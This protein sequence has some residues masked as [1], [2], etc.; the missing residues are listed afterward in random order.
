MS[1][2]AHNTSWLK[3]QLAYPHSLW[4][5]FSVNPQEISLHNNWVIKVSHECWGCGNAGAFLPDR[6]KCKT[7]RP[8]QKQICCMSK[9]IYLSTNL[10]H[11]HKPKHV[12]SRN[13]HMCVYGSIIQK[14]QMWR[15]SS[16][17][18]ADEQ[19][20]QM[21]QAYLPTTYKDKERGPLSLCPTKLLMRQA[22]QTAHSS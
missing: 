17:P 18:A 13:L 22:G 10:V 11:A 5:K 20:N 4:G 19:A 21:W 9:Q 14:R 2:E 8:L 6:Q 12:P 16:Y 1:T 7:V 15:T 3:A